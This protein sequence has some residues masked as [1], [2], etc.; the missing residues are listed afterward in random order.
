MKSLIFTG[1]L[2]KA[3][4]QITT[5]HLTQQQYR[6][7]GIIAVKSTF[8]VWNI[9]NNLNLKTKNAIISVTRARRRQ[10]V[11]HLQS[12]LL[13]WSKTFT[14]TP[15]GC[16]NCQLY[17]L[18]PSCAGSYVLVPQWGKCYYQKNKLIK[19]LSYW[20]VITNTKCIQMQKPFEW[21]CI[22]PTNTQILQ[23]LVRKS[24]SR[25][26]YTQDLLKCL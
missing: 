19:A 20:K 22:F 18:S 21:W 13:Q 23:I 2:H 16:Q 9:V 7:L 24:F 17:C 11:L 14:N 12:L 4:C 15:N 26:I 8:P 1:S 5:Q 25:H 10:G 6:W 3:G